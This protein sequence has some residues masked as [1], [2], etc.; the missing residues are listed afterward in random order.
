MEENWTFF[1][2]KSKYLNMCVE[3]V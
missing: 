2:S 3:F 1:S